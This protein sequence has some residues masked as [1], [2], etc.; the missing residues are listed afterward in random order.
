MSPMSEIRPEQ[1]PATLMQPAMDAGYPAEHECPRQGDRGRD[2]ADIM[3][4]GHFFIVERDQDGQVVDVTPVTGRVDRVGDG[5]I[6]REP[7]RPRPPLSPLMHF[8]DFRPEPVTFGTYVSPTRFIPLKGP[9]EIR[10]EA[11]EMVLAVFRELG[12]D[13]QRPEPAGSETD[14][15]GVRRLKREPWPLI[16]DPGPLDALRLEYEFPF[17]SRGPSRRDPFDAIPV[18]PLPWP[19]RL[20]SII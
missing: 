3:T 9:D 20:S 14:R 7:Q 8:Y 5:Y 1:I 18:L 6:V 15:G 10:R 12:V 19:P 13:P 11:A 2:G 16:E 17:P 4:D